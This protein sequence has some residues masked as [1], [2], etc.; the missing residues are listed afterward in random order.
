MSRGK[1]VGDGPG[2][3]KIG[4]VIG[5]GAFSTVYECTRISDGERFAIK[6]ISKAE[7]RRDP[8]LEDALCREINS[9]E[10]IRHSEFITN[11]IDKLVSPRNFYIVMDLVNGGSLM[12]VVQKSQTGL[13]PN[14]ARLYF[15]QILQGL[16]AIHGSNVVHRDIKPDNMLLDHSKTVL[17]I[18][19]FGFA[20]YANAT[21]QLRRKCGTLRYT[22]PEIFLQD[23]YRGRDVDIWAAGV[24]LY[25]MLFN[26]Y[27]FSCSGD[28]QNEM[29]EQITKGS[30]EL[31]R[32]VNES[33]E[34]L[35]SVM[36]RKDPKKRWTLDQVKSHAWVMGIDEITINIPRKLT[37]KAS[38]ENVN[39]K[40]GLVKRD[41]DSERSSCFG[42]MCITPTANDKRFLLSSFLLD[43]EPVDLSEDAFFDEDYLIGGSHRRVRSCP[44]LPTVFFESVKV[45]TRR[46]GQCASGAKPNAL[47]GGEGAVKDVSPSD[48]RDNILVVR[49][50]IRLSDVH[51]STSPHHVPPVL[52]GNHA[53]I[54][55]TMPFR[56]SFF[57]D[58]PRIR[59]I[60]AAPPLRQSPAVAER[61]STTTP[62]GKE[63][64]SS[65]RST[66][67]SSGNTSTTADPRRFERKSFFL[68]RFGFAHVKILL[69]F[70]VFCL[71]L[72][73]V[74]ALRVLFD[75]DVTK[76][77][78]PAKLRQLIESV[79]APPFEREGD[80]L[81]TET[82][83]P[84]VARQSNINKPLDS[85]AV[86]SKGKP[87]ATEEDKVRPDG[88]KGTPEIHSP[89]GLR[90]R[91]VT[92]RVDSEDFPIA[93][94]EPL[95]TMMPTEGIEPEVHP[96]ARTTS[97]IPSPSLRPSVRIESPK[98]ASS[99]KNTPSSSPTKVSPAVAMTRMPS[100]EDSC[101]ARAVNDDDDREESRADDESLRKGMRQVVSRHEID[102][103]VDLEDELI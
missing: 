22:A 74:G 57:T 10:T 82:E 43:E 4:N 92:R 93:A 84:L 87:A 35:L 97:K 62:K 42:S 31:P 9:M 73:L 17:K 65:R 64:Q 18:S 89:S 39:G 60:A 66:P 19:D 47:C 68:K 71:V 102:D 55:H 3:Y 99:K 78:I 83:S 86:T 8:E 91:S 7:M 56:E 72:L 90:R 54:L 77:P 100:E 67:S 26:A 23:S 27:P 79:L 13:H 14:R 21:R 38:K 15:R 53:S 94:G 16:T 30:Y 45:D 48:P 32:K 34:H 103:L 11:M 44:T 101:F 40:S 20:C 75:A 2:Q 58:V 69:N 95:V 81:G 37:T 51:S 98:Q 76:W 70:C 46:D 36:L 50:A 5:K 1:I 33:L 96:H 88:A 59:S 41:E 49:K 29:I 80:S 25:I 52:P 28:D 63:T 61:G 85:D 12:Q 24:T 6:V